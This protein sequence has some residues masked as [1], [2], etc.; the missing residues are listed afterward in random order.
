[1]TQIR[2][3]LIGFGYRG[4]QLL[5]LMR[6]TGLFDIV[7]IADI[8]VCGDDYGAAC[9]QGDDAYVAMLDEQRPDLAVITTPW[10]LHVAQAMACAERRCHVAIE[11]KG[12]L[13]LGEYRPLMDLA[14]RTGTKVFPM[15]NTLFRREILA[16]KRMADEGVLGDIVYLRGGYR[17]DLRDILLDEHGRL[18]GRRGTESVWRS[19]F[20]VERNGD[21]YPTHALG[22]LCMIL[23]VGRRDHLAWLTA[24]A[25]KAVG[26][27][28]RMSDL[29]NGDDTTRVTLGDI[30]ST[31]IE[32]EGGALISLTHDTT[33]PRPRSLDFKV[34]GTRGIWNGVNRQIYVEGVSPHEQWEDDAPYVARYESRYWQM[35]GGEAVE[36]DR[37]HDGMDY[38]ML[39]ALAADLHGEMVYPASLGDLELWTSVSPL[40][41]VSIREHRRV[42]FPKDGK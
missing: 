13:S 29:G 22:P 23:G 2:T 6:S 35:W 18:G 5:S 14:V 8:R 31:Q 26:L 9:Y 10:H 1:M 38:I 4:R 39:R 41:E 19:H 30:V 7:G 15:E 11:I 40:S 12:G 20:Y 28:Q 17:H 16:V 32:T 34:Q 3:V 33:L 25:T 27:H 37:H 36:C 21:L 42:A 24:F